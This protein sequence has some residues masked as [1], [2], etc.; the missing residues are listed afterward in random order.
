M[1][2]RI[3]ILGLSRDE[4]R[5]EMER[6]G[7]PPYRADQLRRWVFQRLTDDWSVMTDLSQ[8]DR[9]R[10][11]EA[12]A[13]ATGRLVSDQRA[14]D[15]VRKLLLAWPD[16]ATSEAVL[17][18]EKGPFLV[19]GNP[20]KRGT[21]PLSRRTACISC[22][23]GCPVGCRFCASG[24]GGLGR[25]LTAGEMVE[26]VWQLARLAGPSGPATA[27]PGRGPAQPGGRL[28]NVVFMGVGEPL[29]N[30]AAVV[31]AVRLIN[32]PD[33]PNVGA[34]KI[35]VSTI[36]LPAQ[37]R[38]LA[39]EDLQITLAISLHAPNQ[40]LR[41][42]LIPWAAKFTLD[43]VLSAARY[44]F[45][46]TGR[47]ITLEYVMLAGVNTSAEQAD[48]LAELAHSLRCN[49]NLIYYN[50]VKGLGFER[51]A[52]ATAAAFRDHLARRGV[53]VHIRASRGLTIDAACGQLRR[54]LAGA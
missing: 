10:L 34:R 42:K 38:Q 47:E 6:L 49:V 30:Y 40:A 2:A 43:E 14:D 20:R 32:T 33:G 50:P 21:A 39:D 54:R 11:A 51:P 4:L 37:I 53:N 16:E 52:Q 24:L 44:Y 17:I 1:T 31:K 35:T 18:P 29:A 15:G 27:Q 13:L 22:Q 12:F 48:E 9:G 3:H 7:L 36:G 46:K 8:A 26:Q 45:A 23:A 28:S 25:N 19:S 5:G 41:A